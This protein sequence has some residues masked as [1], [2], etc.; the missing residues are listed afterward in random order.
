MERMVVAIMTKAPQT[1]EVKTRLCPPL[2]AN[3][4]AELYRCFVLD[5]IEQI[6]MLDGATPA[7]AYTPAERRSFFEELAPGF[8]LVPQHG[9][10]LGARLTNSFDQLFAR[11][12]AG[13]LAVD[14]DTP[15]LPTGF[16]QEA[17]DF[18]A[19]PEIDLVL[20]PTEDGGYYLIGMRK[21]H[22]ELF[23]AM[24]WSTAQ[25]TAET[26]RRAEA[27]GLKVATLP[28]W[29]DV[30]T[31]DDLE[32]LKAS[33]WSSEETAARHTRGFFTERTG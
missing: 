25:V 7:I 32:R 21:L 10:D 19:R 26:L 9:P 6:R 14:S 28:P 20:G 31:P 4:A 11:G 16:L 2:S 29:F 1:G 33:L 8:V 15:T 18:I 23:E 12:Y 22:R 3:E 5:K 30:D 13:V 24:A 17:L 27:H